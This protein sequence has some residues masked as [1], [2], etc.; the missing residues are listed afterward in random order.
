MNLLT[1][2]TLLGLVVLVV[3]LTL[4]VRE[5][6]QEVEYGPLRPQDKHPQDRYTERVLRQ[7][8]ADV[9]AWALP[10]Q[11]SEPDG[12]VNEEPYQK[13]PERKSGL[14]HLISTLYM[15]VGALVWYL[16]VI[17]YDNLARYITPSDGSI[18]DF[19]ILFLKKAVG[20]LIPCLSGVAAAVIMFFMVFPRIYTY[21][22]GWTSKDFDLYSDLKDPYGRSGALVRIAFF[23]LLFLSFF[24]A[25]LALFPLSLQ[26]LTL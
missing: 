2:L 21:L 4:R 23:A 3:L 14:A 1:M 26:D 13:Q 25:F 8:A 12:K 11:A 9:P 7:Q 24:V 22:N 17:W 19:R 15:A 10:D 5:L 6:K 18:G 16:C 20:A